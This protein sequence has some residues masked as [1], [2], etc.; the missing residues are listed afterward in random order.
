[1]LRLVPCMRPCRPCALLHGRGMRHRR[2]LPAAACCAQGFGEGQKRSSSGGA[3]KKTS[4]SDAL[5][6]SLAGELRLFH[7]AQ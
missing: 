4:L 5:T 2:R 6:K 1:M 7:A 3:E